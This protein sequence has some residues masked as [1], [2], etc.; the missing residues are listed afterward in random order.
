MKVVVAIDSFKGSLTSLEAGNAVKEGIEKADKKALVIV[1]PLA[2]GGEGTMSAITQGMGGEL[3]SVRV[4]GPMGNTIDAAYGYLQDGTAI[5]EMAAAAGITLVE[6]STK[7]PLAATTFGV[8]QIIM[9]ALEKGCRKFIIG[10]GGSATNDGGIGM[11]AALGYEFLDSVGQPVKTGAA[12]LSQIHKITDTHVIDGLKE[13]SFYIACD[14]ENPLCGENGATYVYGPQ[15]GVTEVLKEPLDQAMKHYASRVSAFTGKDYSAAKGAGAAGGLGYAFLSFL[16]AQLM[17][18]I[19]LVM[20]A[21]SLEESLMNADYVITG[22]GRIDAQTAMGKGP[23]GVARLAKKQG[24]KVIALAGSIIS[25]AEKCNE[26]GIDAYFSIL[27]KPMSLQEA[28]EPETA[29]EQIKNTA[30]QIWRL[31]KESH[32]EL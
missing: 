8:G 31:I 14:V 10:I 2:D 11:L 6:E 26:A 23:V 17:P 29:R 20:N 12:G 1:K 30:E 22:E 19:D 21:V 18:G 24:A 16:P 9:D 13:C 15:K 4:S 32:L 7:N 5:V 25:G 28:M 27:T 3:L